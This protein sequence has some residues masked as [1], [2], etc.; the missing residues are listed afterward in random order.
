MFRNE[1]Y[2]R[3][4][5]QNDTKNDLGKR[6]FILLGM[7]LNFIELKEAKQA[8]QTFERCLK[9]FPESF[10]QSE[11]SRLSDHR[12]DTTRQDAPKSRSRVVP[13]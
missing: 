11:V 3:A 6:E 12:C 5:K 4:V 10:P 7:G 8:A 2:G 13:R 1:Y 9:E